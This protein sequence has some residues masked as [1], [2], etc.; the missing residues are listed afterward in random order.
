MNTNTLSIPL[1]Q[2]E[3]GKLANERNTSFGC[4]GICLVFFCLLIGF[5]VLL[6]ANLIKGNF[7]SFLGG[8]ILITPI[9]FFIVYGLI[10]SFRSGVKY[11][12]DVKQGRKQIIT[13]SVEGKRV[14]LGRNKAS[15]IS[16]RDFCLCAG[17][18]TVKVPKSFYDEIKEG[19]TISFEIA[20]QS[21]TIFSQPKKI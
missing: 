17:G 14:K 6:A 7:V 10:N 21:E 2:K 1:T 16:S 19:E 18:F 5:F 8:L 3:A 13:A 11:H 4:F 12:S 15:K 9:G 20:P